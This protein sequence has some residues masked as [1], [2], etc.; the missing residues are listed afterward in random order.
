MTLFGPPE[1]PHFLAPKPQDSNDKTAG[2]EPPK[3]SMLR[4]SVLARSLLGKTIHLRFGTVVQKRPRGLFGSDWGD[5]QGCLDDFGMIGMSTGGAEAT[6]GSVEV[7]AGGA[8][9]AS[10]A[11]GM[12]AGGLGATLGLAGDGPQRYGSGFGLGW[13]VC[14]R[15]WG[16]LG[17]HAAFMACRRKTKQLRGEASELRTF[18]G[19]Y[20]I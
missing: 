17:S 18:G 16:G 3:V 11:L 12:A 19:R 9:V 4:G 5:Y 13:D 7:S 15:W 2:N 6:S 1:H 8:D 20:K 10:A 14:W